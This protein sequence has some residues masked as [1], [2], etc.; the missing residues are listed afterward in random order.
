LVVLGYFLL[1]L[2]VVFHGITCCDAPFIFS[3]SM[4]QQSV[5]V[6]PDTE[7][8]EVEGSHSCTISKFYLAICNIQS[9]V[10]VYYPSILCSR[11]L[12]F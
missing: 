1:I 7:Q 8:S 11:V 10:D 9:M 2:A 3:N 6:Y 4:K 5:A 12:N